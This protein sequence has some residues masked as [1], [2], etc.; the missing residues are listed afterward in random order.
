MKP[1]FSK[2]RIAAAA[3]VILLILFLARP[4]VSR[5]KARIANSISRAVARPVEIGS[6]QLRFLPPGFDLENVVVHEDPAFGAEPMLR[7]PEVTAVVRLTSL[8]RG[9]LDISRLELTEP[10]LNLVRRA[11]GRW[12]WEVLLE[13]AARTPLAPTAKSKREARPGFPYIEASSGRINFKSG[14]EKKPYAL[15]DADFSLWQESENA[16]GVRLKAQPLRTDMNQSDTGLLQINGTWQRA[17]SLRETPLQFTLAW[18]HT[19]LGQLSKL[20]T[21]N[22]QGWRG[23]VQM[24]TTLSGTPGAMLV[25]SDAAIRNFH[26]Y[27]ISTSESLGLAAHCE[28]KYSS[29]ENVMHEIFCSAPVGNGVVT[30]H[31][32]AGTPGVHLVDLAVNLD[33]VPA[34]ALAQLIR[35]AK[36]DLP[37]DFVATGSVQGNFTAKEDKASGGVEFRGSGEIANLRMQSASNKADFATGTVP[38]ALGVERERGRD[39]LRGGA[40]GRSVAWIMPGSGETRV[41]VGPIPIALGRPVAAQ[42]RGWMGRSGYGIE[43]RGEGEV[44]RT[45]RLASLLGLQALKSSAEG[46]A[47]MD[48]QVTGSWAENVAENSS[49]FSLPK[50]TGTVQLHNIR[51]RLRGT[52]GAVE[53]SSAELKLSAD[54]A[55]VEKLRARA[56][57]AEWTGWMALPRGCGTPGACL[58][59]FNLN[60]DEVGVSGLHQWL[61]P[62]PRERRWYQVLTPERSNV[63]SFLESVRASGEISAGRVRLRDVVAERVS[64]AIELDR[65]TVTASD[66]RADLLGGMHRGD[67]RADFT[68]AIPVYTGS[69]TLTG[70]SLE[71][72]A[73]AMDDS[74]I[75]GTGGGSYQIKASGRTSAEFWKS[76]E[77]SLHFDLR[78]GTL[79]HIALASD[80]EPLQIGRW[81]GSALLQGGKIEIEKGALIS[82]TAA[83]EVSGTA[84]LGQEL[85]FKVSGGAE[86]KSAAGSLVYSITGTVAEPR[87]AV[88]PAPETQ[89]QLKP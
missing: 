70:I 24:E 7:A 5:L 54:E 31:G 56:A 69:G 36:K 30:M 50:V 73:D 52:N 66:L 1:S 39:P 78:D 46:V 84:S 41:E 28:G 68:S 74:W 51:A 33:N 40:M 88:V 42:A 9:R 44:S 12:N 8:V 86:A 25:V 38:F 18:E 83:Y 6:V 62:Q 76:A 17:G 10:S 85:D 45:L 77:G 26:R 47:Q 2:R 82:S 22:D 34:N 23:D 72:L 37:A 79:P 21:G 3:V 87:V 81:Q 43:L 60:T 75:S 57:D 19:Q 64:A 71:E 11:D 27:D 13:R 14:P 35:R 16:W 89:A 61:G 80:S 53:I 20:V 48:L 49:G 32:D 29:A 4:G 58:V 65:G 59:H 55:R 67:W 15:L 63:A